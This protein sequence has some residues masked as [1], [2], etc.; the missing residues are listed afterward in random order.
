MQLEMLS[1]RVS[2]GGVDSAELQDPASTARSSEGPSLICARDAAPVRSA[3]RG[4]RPKAGVLTAEP[5]RG[6]ARFPETRWGP[7]KEARLAQVG[8]CTQLPRSVD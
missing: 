6:T 2:T 7:S 5:S 3:G 1:C 8:G 4:R